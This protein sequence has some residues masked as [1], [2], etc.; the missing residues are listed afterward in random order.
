MDYE[1]FKNEYKEFEDWNKY[2]LDSCNDGIPGFAGN[3][4]IV[5]GKK[6]VTPVDDRVNHPS[7]YT[8]GK[9]EVIDIIEDAIKD[10]PSNA[11]GMLQA[12]VLKYILRMW[13]KDNPVEDARKAQWYLTR[14]IAKLD[15]TR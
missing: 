9:T 15:S 1:F 5:F 6:E 12:Q 7:H 3:D 4:Y 11:E 13:L 10:A 14:L 2:A 8:S